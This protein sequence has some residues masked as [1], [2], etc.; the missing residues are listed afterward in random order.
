MTNRNLLPFLIWCT[1]EK[2]GYGRA[3]NLLAAKAIQDKR[4]DRMILWADSEFTPWPDPKT[5]TAEEKRRWL[6]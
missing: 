2:R 6:L 5:A 1:T 4:E 3:P